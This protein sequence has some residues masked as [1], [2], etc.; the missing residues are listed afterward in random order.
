MLLGAALTVLL[1]FLIGRA[2]VPYV[3]LSPGPT[4][5]TLGAVDR[6][7]DACSNPAA[8]APK[9][10]GATPSPK[11][12]PD[13]QQ[14]IQITGIPTSTG[15]GQ[16]R[17]VT[18]SV[19]SSMTLVDTIRGWISGS[20]AVIPRK[21]IY[22][23]DK[24]EQQVEQENKQEFENSQSSAETAALTELG[25]P[26]KVTVTE[27]TPDGAAAGQLQS[28]DIINTV[29][30][31]PV[32]STQKLL[33][34]I[35]AKP[36]GSTLKIGYTRGA[37][38][39]TASITTKAGTDGTPRVGIGVKTIQPH[40]FE[41]NIKLDKIGGPSAGMM[42]ALGIIDKIKSEDLTNG[43][44]VAGT[45]TIDDEGNVGPI[46]GVTQ[47]L[48][49]AKDAGATIFLTPATNCEEAKSNVPDG[50][51]LVKVST[52][53]EALAALAALPNGGPLPS[54]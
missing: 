33:E 41:L 9:P 51:R 42:F 50:L 1:G 21:L 54:C 52:L 44:V 23:E 12:E 20:E 31:T 3:A 2:D 38:E 14:V 25:Y 40:P 29:D 16:L 6:H 26:V 10:S 28:N 53:D 49:G 37:D 45:G 27:V 8:P 43:F 11:A 17:M 18:V 39:G 24:T 5:D 13:C 7:G 22:P 30:G 46:G 19:Q 36:V 35:Q 4:V 34:L 32:T 48:Y 15:K 47:K